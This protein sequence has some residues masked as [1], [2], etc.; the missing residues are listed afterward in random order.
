MSPLIFQDIIH[1]HLAALQTSNPRD[2]MEADRI[3]FGKVPQ[4]L[5][6]RLYKDVYKL[7]F[8]VLGYKYPHEYINMGYVGEHNNTTGKH[9]Q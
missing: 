5:I 4:S 1:P 9:V 2:V 8:D 6:K 3:F 7:D